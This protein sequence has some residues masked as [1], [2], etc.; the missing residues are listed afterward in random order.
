MPR[1]VNF[2]TYL[3]HSFDKSLL[4]NKACI[5]PSVPYYWRFFRF[6]SMKRLEVF[7]LQAECCELVHLRVSPTIKFAWMERDTA[8]VK[9]LA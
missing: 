9:R 5:G 8:R 1:P 3:L 7:L 4:E 6:S 2:L